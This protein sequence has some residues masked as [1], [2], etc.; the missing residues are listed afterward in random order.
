MFTRVDEVS[1][2]HPLSSRW[3]SKVRVMSP[4]TLCSVL[5][6]NIPS[7]PSASTSDGRILAF[8][9]RVKPTLKIAPCKGYMGVV[10]TERALYS[11]LLNPNRTIETPPAC[12]GKPSVHLHNRAVATYSSQ[13]AQPPSLEIYRTF[14]PQPTQY[15]WHTANECASRLTSPT[16]PTVNIARW[17]SLPIGVRQNSVS[18]TGLADGFRRVDRRMSARPLLSWSLL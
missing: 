18:T 12:G 13:E 1:S 14:I 15:E 7:L 17:A 16:R 2:R 9:H 5:L 10:K 11:T 6:P 3:I 8:S 4:T